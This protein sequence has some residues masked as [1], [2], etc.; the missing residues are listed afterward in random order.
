MRYKYPFRFVI[1]YTNLD[2]GNITLPADAQ[3]R[4]ETQ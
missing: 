4:V 1:P 2:L 3:M